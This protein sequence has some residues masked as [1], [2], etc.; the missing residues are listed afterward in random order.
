M[1]TLKKRKED[2]KNKKYK[3]TFLLT[4]IDE[5]YKNIM[6]YVKEAKLLLNHGYFD[7]S[8]T[9]SYCALEELGKRLIVCDYYT[10]MLSEKE[11]EDAFNAHKLK[12]AYL[13]NYCKITNDLNGEHEFT[14]TYDE[15]KY[16]EWF[17][18][19]NESL[20]INIKDNE[21]ISPLTSINKEEAEEIYQYLIKK[22]KETLEYERITERLGS[23]AFYK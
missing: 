6:S 7:R 15:S 11:F 5:C 23:K 22:I 8:L 17:D 16:K 4:I 3:D 14:I 19:R 2:I 20:Y 10:E 1:E 18:K 12:I 9:L 13:H 21:V